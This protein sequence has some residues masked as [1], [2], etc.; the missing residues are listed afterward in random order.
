VSWWSE[1]ITGL[2]NSAVSKYVTLKDG[3]LG[4]ATD[5]TNLTFACKVLLAVFI[6]VKTPKLY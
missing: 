5:I 3:T 2:D 6:F 4:A 1:K